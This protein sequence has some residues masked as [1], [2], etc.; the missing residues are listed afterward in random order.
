MIVRFAAVLLPILVAASSAAEPAAPAVMSPALDAGIRRDPQASQRVWIF[1]TDKQTSDSSTLSA[2]L[3][4]RRAALPAKTVARREL[5]GDRTP[6]L[7]FADLPV[8]TT[9]L[10]AIRATGAKLRH[11]SRWLNA[12]SADVTPEQLRAIAALPFVRLI[13]PVAHAAPRP[14]M[15]ATPIAAQPATRGV[16]GPGFY[17]PAY[18]QL[19]QIGV[20]AAHNAGF[21]GNGIVVG[22]LDTGFRLTHSA[23]NQTVAAH[24]V[25]VLDQYDFVNDDANAGPEPAD[26]PDQHHHG[27]YILGTL[28]AYNPGVLVGAAYDAAYVLAKTEDV[29]QEVPAEEDNYVAGLEW[30]EAHGADLATSSL[31]YID[32]YTQADLDGQ[33]AV[34]TIAVN[35]ATA[36]GLVCCTAAGNG[37]NDAST[38][39]SHLIAP[40]DAFRVLTC[41]A[42]DLNGV[43]AGFSSD[44]PTADG[45]I[46]PELLARG[47]DTATVAAEDNAAIISVNGTSLSTPLLAGATALLIQAHPDWNAEKIRRVLLHTATGFVNTGLPDFQ[48]VRGYGIVNVEAAINFVEGD[49]NQDGLANG[50]DIAAF[51]LAVAQNNPDLTERILSD[52]DVDG[53]V[54]AADVPIFIS[55]LLGR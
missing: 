5:R 19:N 44:G 22:I 46:K 40:A 30:I 42:V 26:P 6:S 8:S 12:Q 31:G 4:S 16:I 55:D 11:T 51:S 1:L 28:G 18:N 17:G 7:E 48:S 49:I 54:S 3:A 9:Y 35:T 13:Q 24:P 41:G 47:V 27:T 29:S 37:G 53:H 50:D 10:D 52:L 38:A 14:P 36:L 45:R 25:H 20:V 43:I 21:T 2:A 34:T 15:P 23:F 33:T 32:W 39:T